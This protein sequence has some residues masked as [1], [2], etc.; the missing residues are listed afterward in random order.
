MERLFAVFTADGG[1]LTIG[2]TMLVL[3]FAFF[4]FVLGQGAL[5]FKRLKQA[6]A[7]VSRY[8][9]G[10]LAAVK[11]DLGQILSHKGLH[12]VWLEYADTLHE[13]V[14]TRNAEDEVV[15]L[16][17]TASAE[18]FFNAET[19]IDPVMHNEFFR[20]LPGIF[21]GIGIIGTF[22]GLISG[23]Q[24]FDA[25]AVEPDALKESLGGLFD[26]VGNAFVISASA[27]VLA[28][29]CTIVEKLIYALNVDKLGRLVIDLDG[30]FSAGVGEEYLSRLVQHSQEGADQTRQLKESLVEDLKVLLTNLTE[31]QIA[32]TAQLS[33]DIGSSLRSSLEEPLQKIAATV[34]NASS[35][36]S[37]QASRM[38]ESLMSRFMTQMQDSMGGQMGELS[39]LMAESAGSMTRVELSLRNLVDD[40]RQTSTQ[41]TQGVQ[42]VMTQL[43][44]SLAE[45]ERD[46][47]DSSQGM[48]QQLLAQ[49]QSAVQELAK[50]Q[51]ASARQMA[52]AA[53]RASNEV[54]QAAGAAQQVGAAAMEKA[55]QLQESQSVAIQAALVELDQVVSRLSVLMGSLGGTFE[56]LDG[57]G[58][59]LAQVHDQAR[60]LTERMESSAGAIRTT[61]DAMVAA[62]QS[63]NQAGG[64]MEKASELVASEAHTRAELL[65][66]LNKAMAQSQQAA[67]QFGQ[68]SNEVSQGLERVFEQFGKGTSAVLERSLRDF[69]KELSTA[70]GSLNEVITRFTAMA[71]KMDGKR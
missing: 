10:A 34:Q 39:R 69:D 18:S 65:S 30:L 56:R 5:L 49:V 61:S 53:A 43:L 33:Q 12:P 44:A 42:D 52:E 67:G 29:F 63:L 21:T 45:H 54:L 51:E 41:S 46:R 13:Q 60:S 15:S 68:Y 57:A 50:A 1:H 4:Y 6:Q 9:L 17:A 35:D 48:Q 64:R 37:E 38:I 28:M 40:L 47:A 31:R 27:I 23:L 55:T 11:P 20:H 58:A 26:H 19:V 36:Q 24:G 71:L 2:V 25:S 22:M 32:A 62:S 70:I 7:K 14:V 66:D 8:K 16:R 3:L 59:K